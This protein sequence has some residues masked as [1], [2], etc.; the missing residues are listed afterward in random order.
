[1]EVYG[2]KQAG[3]DVFRIFL[4]SLGD[5]ELNYGMSRR[6]LK[7][8]DV[9]RVSMGGDVKPTLGELLSRVIKGIDRIP[10]LLK[11]KNVLKAMKKVKALYLNY[12][13]PSG[14]NEWKKEV[15]RAFRSVQKLVVK[16]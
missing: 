1:M 3:L 13:D 8:E 9:L 15:D 5:E 4:Q 16:S 14:F 12:P 6:L 7:E 2:A 10:F 11:L